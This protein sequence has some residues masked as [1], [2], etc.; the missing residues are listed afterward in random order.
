[1]ISTEVAREARK[2]PGIFRFDLC[3]VVCPF[4]IGCRL[5]STPRTLAWARYRADNVP[6]TAYKIE[7]GESPAK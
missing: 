7:M 2:N 3:H 1:M 6:V 5:L 4:K